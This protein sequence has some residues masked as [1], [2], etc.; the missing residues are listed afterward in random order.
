MINKSIYITFIFITGILFSCSNTKKVTQEEDKT[1]V[2]DRTRVSNK[3]K[4][5]FDHIFFNAEKEKILGN[6]ELAANLY[7]QCI[8][9]NP[10]EPTP[11]FELSKLFDF[12]GDVNT[13][14]G[15][16]KE[17]A[18]LNPE[19]Y[20][21]AINYAQLLQKNNKIS[22]AI[23]VFKQIIEKNQ[24]KPT[25]YF[26]L[27][28]M[29]IY[30]SE[31]KKA[32]ETYNKLEGIIGVTEEISFQKQKAYIK[33]NDVDKAADE[34]K[35]LINAYPST[36]QY[37]GVLADLYS[38]NNRFEEALQALKKIEEINPEDPLISLSLSDYYKNIGN[39]EKSFEYLK[40][41]FANKDLEVDTKM[42]ILLS[43][44]TISESNNDV[45]KKAY[46]LVN[47]LI[48]THPKNAKGYTIHA[49]F[50]YRDKKVKE[51]LDN[52]YKAKEIDDSKFAIWQQ[53]LFLESELSN[54][55]AILI[56]SKK[57]I[58]L[59]PNQPLFYFFYGNTN[60]IEEKYQE[61]LDYLIM[62][63]DY[64]IDNLALLTQFYASIGDAY[65]KLNQYE[66]SDIYYEK[67]LELD[68]N[69]IYVLNNYS[70]YLSLR[71]EKLERAAELSLKSNKLEPN[72]SNYQDTYAW[73]L[74]KQGN[75]LEAKIWLDKAI[76]NGGDKNGVILEHLGDV[77]YKLDKI[78]K[79]LEYW[80]K[81]KEKGDASN[82]IEKKIKDKKF[83][84][85]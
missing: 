44:Y 48:Q 72:Q 10:N 65:Y 29:Y 71:G 24:E 67:A 54:N 52:Y 19:N 5:Q 33:L 64:V 47:I 59:F 61:G 9:L 7:A 43:Y 18:R 63:K 38:A 11:F 50:L 76:K 20:W 34:I 73:V 35:N 6:T 41:A 85:Q 81:A 23:E 2:K 15:Y 3:A 40:K 78:E 31:Y 16:A 45:K 66:K 46:E 22:E 82:L 37:Y 75:Y 56:E 36:Y 80:Q 27:A 12:S 58:D 62:G 32:I 14:L 57:A 55:Q 77:Y 74:F 28:S 26:E 13:A 30:K 53:I 79:A 39:Q 83:Y 84:E 21:F 1:I 69:N 25:L 60:L 70:Y 51:A 49:D 17:A 68:P 4:V 42:Q 8:R